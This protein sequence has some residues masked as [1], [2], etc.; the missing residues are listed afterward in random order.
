MSLLQT[1]STG[2]LPAACLWPSSFGG[3]AIVTILAAVACCLKVPCG[4]LAVGEVGGQEG[5]G[6]CCPGQKHWLRWA[7]RWWRL[8]NCHLLP[9]NREDHLPPGSNLGSM[10]PNGS[11][12]PKSPLPRAAKGFSCSAWG[13]LDPTGTPLLLP[14]PTHQRAGDLGGF[15]SLFLFYSSSFR[16][17]RSRHFHFP[18]AP[19]SRSSGESAPPASRNAC[20][21]RPAGRVRHQP[22]PPPG[23]TPRCH[24]HGPRS[25]FFFFFF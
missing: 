25:A 22:M 5:S 18:S 6:C 11:L 12:F 20:A 13:R 16:G 4:W 7:S 19:R 15:P 1:G 14:S 9:R 8:R 23:T 24:R 2:V 17:Q 10:L 3:C 21:F